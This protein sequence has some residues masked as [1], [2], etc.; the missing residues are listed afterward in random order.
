M[1]KKK[2]PKPP[3]Y[4]V[5]LFNNAKV[6]LLRSRDEADDYLSRL[7]LE[8][9]TTGY[10]GFAYDH[11]KGRKIPLLIIAVFLHE[12]SVLAHEVCH[13]AFDICNHVGVPTPNDEM[14]ETY[15]YLVQR[16]LQEFLPYIKQD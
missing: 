4:R 6:V 14:N 15:C 9:D 13:I 1:A 16:I 3:E 12:P 5:P 10:D 11:R 7:G 8:F 2:W